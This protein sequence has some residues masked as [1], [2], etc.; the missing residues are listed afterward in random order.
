MD[1]QRSLQPMSKCFEFLKIISSWPAGFH[2]QLNVTIIFDLGLFIQMGRGS[3][4]ALLSCIQ[5]VFS[6][7][8][9]NY[10]VFNQ[11]FQLVYTVI[12]N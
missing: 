12:F 10:I 2:L 5:P 7:S 3:G 1:V 4:N 6:T 9:F 11:C 8:V